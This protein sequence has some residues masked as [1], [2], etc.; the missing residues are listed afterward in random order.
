MYLD[1]R[2][3]LQFEK[4]AD[5]TGFGGERVVTSRIDWDTNRSPQPIPLSPVEPPQRRNAD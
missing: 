2:Y 4:F 1:G 5:R 3:G